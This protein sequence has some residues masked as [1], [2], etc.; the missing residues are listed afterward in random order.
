MGD[1]CPEPHPVGRPG[2]ACAYGPNNGQTRLLVAM[3]FGVG[4]MVT[5]L[6]GGV[7]W[8]PLMTG[9][10]PHG[11]CWGYHEMDPRCSWKTLE[12]NMLHETYDGL[13]ESEELLTCEQCTAVLCMVMS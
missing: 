2:V 5:R 1:Q 10:F 3:A 12:K 8:Y 4:V 13:L 11:H 7:I 9:S 6:P